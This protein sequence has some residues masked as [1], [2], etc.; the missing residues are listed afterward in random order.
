MTTPQD[1]EFWEERMN[2]GARFGQPH[3][4]VLDEP[5]STWDRFNRETKNVLDQL[6]DFYAPSSV[7]DAACGVGNL[8]EYVPDPISYT[9]VDFSPH[10]IEQARNT[11]PDKKFEVMDLRNLTFSSEKFDLVFCRGVEGVII[12]AFGQAAW[13]LIEKELLRVSKTVLVCISMYYSYRFEVI[14]KL[15]KRLGGIDRNKEWR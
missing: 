13:D 11:Y 12:E 5:A 4:S 15:G 8:N 9:G 7:L 6:L 3:R 14:N 10:M 2:R 1:L